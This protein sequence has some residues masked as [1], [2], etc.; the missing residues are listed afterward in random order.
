M[1]KAKTI[2]WI[3]ATP[4]I[5]VAGGIA[6]CEANKA[7][8]DHKVKQWCEKDGGVTVYEKVELTKEE[9]ERNDGKDGVIRVPPEISSVAKNYD[10]VWKS[11]DTVINKSMPKVVKYEAIVYQ[12]SNKK[13]LGKM[14]SYGRTGGDFPTIIS[15]GSSFTCDDIEGISLDAAKQIF[16]VN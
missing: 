9:Y 6:F 3:I 7:Y 4:F 16:F 14:V 13:Q 8:W 15:V 5:L 2:G 12:K 11:V 10:Y 1:S